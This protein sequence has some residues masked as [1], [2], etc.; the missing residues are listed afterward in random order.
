MT[1]ASSQ[2]PAWVTKRDGRLVPFEADKISR[3][4][5]AATETLGRPDAFLAR[6]LTDGIVHFLV[7]EA[8]GATPTTVQVRE[9]VIKVVRELGQPALAE[10]FTSHV[11]ATTPKHTAEEEPALPAAEEIR[12]PL[13][14]PP[15][16]FVQSCLR[17]YTLRQVFT[18][19]LVSAHGD[20][21]L[22]L[23][24]LEA[25]AE[26]AG[27]VLGPTGAGPLGAIVQA[28]A[29]AGGL[30]VIDG[31]EHVLARV[32]RGDAAVA[33]YVRELT[34]GLRATDLRAVVNLNC[35]A[36]PPWAGELADGP[37][38][39][40]QRQAP[41]SA[42]LGQ[43]TD[44][45]LDALR[46]ADLPRGALR[47]DWHLGERD[48]QPGAEARLLRVA[49]LAAESDRIAFVFDRPRRPVLL[50]EGTD[51]THPAVLLTVGLHLP[52]LADQPGVGGDPARFLQ[53]LGSLARLALSA[54]VQKREFLRRR[55][56]RADVTRGFLLPR[57]RLV[58]APVGLESVAR[59][60]TG[61]G[62]CEGKPTLDFARQ[63]VQRLRDVLRQD[64]RLCLMETCLDAPPLGFR[65]A[66]EEVV[67]GH[68]E[69]T[70]EGQTYRAEE[71]AGVTAWDARAEV[72]SQLR[73]AGTLHGA[74]EMGTAAVFLP[75]ASA[76]EHMAD[77]LRGAWQQTDLA[78]L[79]FLR[80]APV[81]Q[82][83]T[84]GAC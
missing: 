53:K 36:P 49:R 65:L 76:A 42:Y 9:L 68:G 32:S 45:L 78:R 8:D 56:D 26:L 22:T 46:Q 48:F 64:G 21:L 4:L 3:A 66:G 31:P 1:P 15:A 54:A 71:A 72:K 5:F 77:W 50:A 35:A 59:A 39:A 58:A 20:G 74:A 70:A 7:A 27:C 10:V 28:R 2:P 30:I 62:L 23:T 79:R 17:A 37:L 81:P 16:A 29:F 33:D 67:P 52:Q 80:A 73:A 43:L 14:G 13:M 44:A 19:D 63:V 18:R 57:A 82:Q 84:L 69:P 55:S 61:R 83:L 60:F 38:F 51:R 41:A 11:P 34:L 25:P 40:A 75:E 47:I 24:G 6:E 12:V